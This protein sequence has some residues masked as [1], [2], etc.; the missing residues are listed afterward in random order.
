MPRIDQAAVPMVLKFGHSANVAFC[1]SIRA[2]ARRCC[3]CYTTTTIRS[4][5]R[6]DTVMI[7]VE[8]VH[9]VRVVRLNGKHRPASMKLWMGDSI[10][11]WEGETFVIETTNF[12]HG[13]R[14]PRRIGESQGHRATHPSE[15][16]TDRLPLHDR[17]SDVIRNVRGRAS[18][19]STRRSRTSTNTRA[20]KA[21]THSRAFSPA[22]AKRSGRRQQK[23]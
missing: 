10:G 19:R 13:P 15:P 5:R 22:R 20:T 2:L 3:R 18:S 4:C 11:R 16:A 9:D 14:F 12:R 8:M 23:K 17:R 21:T 6:K 7:H 1:R